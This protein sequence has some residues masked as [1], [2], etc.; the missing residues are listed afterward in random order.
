MN[1]LQQLIR[2]QGTN[3]QIFIGKETTDDP[4]YNTKS[5]AYLNPFPI[6][7]LVSQVGF[8]SSQWRMPGI[9]ASKVMEITCNKRHKNLIEKSRKIVIDS[10]EYVGWRPGEG[11]NIQYKIMD[12]Y[13]Q[14]LVHTT[15]L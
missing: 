10:V 12:D 14:L 5:V 15:T 3:I 4:N 9:K 11:N 8:T 6:K 7:A 2:E 13:I 1:E